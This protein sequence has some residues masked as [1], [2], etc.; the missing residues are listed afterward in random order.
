MPK[1]LQ[2]S[3]EEVVK[4]WK[5]KA[6]GKSVLQISLILN[7]SKRGI[8]SV[9]QRGEQFKNAYR[10][11][12]PRRTTFREDRRIK[13]MALTD[14]LSLNQIKN[15]LGSQI[16]RDTIRRRITESGFIKKQKL[17]RKPFLKQCH[18]QARLQWAKQ[19]MHY[20]DEWINVIFSDEKKWNLDGT[21]GFSFY[22][23]DLRKDPKS[24]F[25][26]QQ[27]GGSLMVWGAFV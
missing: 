18:K 3:S 14:N 13:R 26:R 9:L 21:D 1:S 7:R 25:S 16:S 11:G 2:F 19:H 5:L 15:R 20:R 4:I 17:A 8:Y 24:I 10:S 22:W 12:R 6:E 23:R 27:G